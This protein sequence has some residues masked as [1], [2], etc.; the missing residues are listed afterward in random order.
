MSI[1]TCS[2]RMA[3][4]KCA[5]FRLRC[6]KLMAM[7]SLSANANV[8]RR[9]ITIIDVI[10]AYERVSLSFS[11]NHGSF[12]NFYRRSAA[13][14]LHSYRRQKSLSRHIIFDMKINM[15]SS[16]GTCKMHGRSVKENK[17]K[18][19]RV[20]H[21]YAGAARRLSGLC[22]SN[23][24]RYFLLMRIALNVG[25]FELIFALFRQTG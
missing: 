19:I 14:L 15:I 5:I 25:F 9:I 17:K 2:L 20:A 23:A 22:R 12:P 8:Q 24:K 1:C 6:T 21:A 10:V 13:R 7:Y 16:T 3:L 4:R 11:A 18:L